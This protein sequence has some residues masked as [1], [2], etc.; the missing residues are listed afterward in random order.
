MIDG[1]S[2]RPENYV[3]RKVIDSFNEVFNQHDAN[4]LGTL[5]TEDTVFED[6]SPAPDGRRVEGKTNVVA[7][8]QGWFARNPDA[9]FEAEEILVMGDR[10]IVRWIYHKMRDGRPWH[11]RGVDIFTVRE[12]KVAAKL[13]YVKG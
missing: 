8:W 13:A 5:L 3:T 1:R 11:L 10:A 12:G 6:T 4:R 9:R 7:F 2:I